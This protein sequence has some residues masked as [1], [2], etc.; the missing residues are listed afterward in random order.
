MA[1][2]RCLVGAKISESTSLTQQHRELV[3]SFES[4]VKDTWFA[5]VDK[6]KK[7]VIYIY[8]EQSNESKK[9]IW[10]NLYTNKRTI[11]KHAYSK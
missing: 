5:R 9:P 2:L 7:T 3:V 10:I 8:S 6:G 11:T 1:D 4:L